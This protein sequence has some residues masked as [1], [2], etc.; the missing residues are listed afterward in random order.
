MSVADVW[1]WSCMARRSLSEAEAESRALDKPSR[2][3]PPYPH[4]PIAL[5]L[6]SQHVREAAHAFLDGRGEGGY[7]GGGD[8]GGMLI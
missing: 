2:L 3:Q 1:Q 4:L 8:E 7:E 5:L 6:C